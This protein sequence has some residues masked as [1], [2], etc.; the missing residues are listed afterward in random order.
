[1]G[2][3]PY[4]LA[5][6]LRTRDFSLKRVLV[7]GSGPMGTE[8]IRALRAM[9][10]SRIAVVTMIEDTAQAIA[11]G[12]GVDLRIGRIEEQLKETDSFD[13]VVVATPIDSLLDVARHVVS[14]GQRNVLIEK[15]GSLWSG[16]LERF[17]HEAR[18]TGVRIRL[19]YNRN[20]YPN[21]LL[22]E[23][24]AA[25]E[26][27]IVSCKYTFTEW[28]SRID[29][30]KNPLAVYQR[31]GISNSL[32]P[33]GM[34]HRLIGM[35]ERLST[36][37]SG[38]L[39]WHSSGSRFAGSGRTK[40]G[41]SFEYEADWES[42]GRWTIEVSTS[43]NSYRLVPLETL[44]VRRPR[45]SD[46]SPVDFAVA[47]PGAKPGVGE[48]LAVMLDPLLE[49]SLPLPTLS[50]GVAL[51]RLAEQIFGYAPDAESAVT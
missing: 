31:W 1:V 2:S 19:A 39:H 26:D 38:S 3:S 37:R 10:V 20:V 30:K 48:E 32:H 29:F 7:I 45:A 9:G 25:A 21:L 13:L 46:W 50:D 36:S 17:E 43:Q 47:Y 5:T 22:L 23:Q 15:P 41:V 27:G 16:S 11:A 18:K 51:I 14:H 12:F 40:T 42:S 33:I 6:S 44:S 8:H 35:P 4:S 24:L 49:P 28:A 34:A